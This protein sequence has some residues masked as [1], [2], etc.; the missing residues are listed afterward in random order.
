MARTKPRKVCPMCNE[1]FTDV[2][3][4]T[5]MCGRCLL[6]IASSTCF[7]PKKDETEAPLDEEAFKDTMLES[8]LADEG[9]VEHNPDLPTIGELKG[10]F[11][12]LEIVS[13]LGAGGMGAVFKARQ[14]VLE[15]TVAL[16]I[17]NKR[18]ASDKQFVA[19]FQREAKAMAKL[20][21]SNIVGIHDFGERGGFYF[22]V[23]EYVD[24]G[25]LKQLIEQERLAPVAALSLI[26]QMCE[27]V[28]F[29]HDQGITHRDIKPANILIDR[30]G[31]VKVADFGL[32]KLTQGGDLENSFKTLPGTTMGTPFYMA[33]E[34]MADA[35]SVDQR[36]DIYSLG[37][38]IYQVLTGSLPHGDFPPPSEAAPDLD[39]NLDDAV[40]RALARDPNLRYDQVKELVQALEYVR[41]GG[42]DVGLFERFTPESPKLQALALASGI[43]GVVVFFGV[44]GLLAFFVL[45]DSPDE[46]NG[47]TEVV[48][49]TGKAGEVAST[50]EITGPITSDRPATVVV[51]D[52]GTVGRGV[53]TGVDS[54]TGEFVNS[55]GMRFVPVPGA[56]VQF[57]IW[58]TRVRDYDVFAGENP[59]VDPEWKDGFDEGVQTGD[60]P[61]ANVS[62]DDAVAFCTWLTERER[63]AGLIDGSQVYRLPTDT[64]WS[65]AIGVA[66]LEAS[67][68]TPGEE[69][70]GVYPWGSEWPPPQGAGNYQGEEGGRSTALEG[71]RDDFPFTAP[72]GSFSANEHGLYDLSGNVWEWCQDWFEDAKERR[73]LRGSSF[74]DSSETGLLSTRR[75]GAYPDSRRNIRGF[76]C[77]L[78]AVEAGN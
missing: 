47:G 2:G 31:R 35:E 30:T 13:V 50:G 44:V 72:V 71:Y 61:V 45:G 58:E 12:E 23:M 51:A 34:Q 43:A 56:G 68:G 48:G 49:G 14:K 22:L 21:H 70:P 41:S 1:T 63:R 76:R 20:D 78:A 53:E 77:V 74:Y 19:R 32:A 67:S 37:V 7:G 36:A 42:D 28:Q 60:H 27:A 40:M 66:E 17:L 57:S 54:E 18:L 9:K 3:K 62:W 39:P 24:G 6:E 11:P 25:D 15:R 38:V 4:D 5:N 75:Y 26:P 33:P 10:L 65:W 73:M 16:K 46:E 8:G 59:S 64:E 52:S 69:I 55:L 29:A